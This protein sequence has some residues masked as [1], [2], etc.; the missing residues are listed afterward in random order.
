MKNSEIV[1]RIA[2]QLRMT[3]KDDYVSD[4]FILSVAKTI[5]AKFLTQ[6]VQRR[7]I[8]R[9]AD[10]YKEIKCIEFEPEE[11]FRCNYVEFKSCSKLSKSVKSIKDIGLVYTRY[12]SS[13]KELYSIDR[14]STVFTESTLYQLRTDSAREGSENKGN[15]FYILDNHIYVPREITE[16]S[17]LILALDQYELDDIC[18]CEENCE[19]AWDKEFIC[20]DSMVEDVIG[21]AIQN[22]MQTKQIQEDGKPDL[23]NSTK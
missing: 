13:I 1:S 19:S 14:M 5:A 12:G 16:L 10:L 11:I 18:S 9:E 21:Y 20:S 17:G 23:N 6:K 15:K 4:R 22:I 7:Y 2:N 8:D 3:S